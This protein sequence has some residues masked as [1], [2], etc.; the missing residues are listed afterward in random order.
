MKTEKIWNKTLKL[1]GKAGK[2]VAIGGG[3]DPTFWGFY[4]SEVPDAVKKEIQM[5]RNR[6]KQ[7]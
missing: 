4:E 7:C 1:V 5:R 6:K 3:G 2:S